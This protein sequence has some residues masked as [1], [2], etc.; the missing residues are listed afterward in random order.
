MDRSRVKQRRNLLYRKPIISGIDL[1]RLYDSRRL[2]PNKLTI[3]KVKS[4][5]HKM[6]RPPLPLLGGCAINAGRNT[7]IFDLDDDTALI[8]LGSAS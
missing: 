1:H 8:S 4:N 6:V 7:D 5:I 2:S 3:H